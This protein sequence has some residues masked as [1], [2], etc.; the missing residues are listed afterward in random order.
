MNRIL[1]IRPLKPALPIDRLIVTPPLGIMYL[2]SV[3][4]N[5]NYEV[6]ILDM[7]LNKK[8]PDYYID[9]IR[10]F[11]PQAVGFSILTQE[12]KV[13]RHM[14]NAIKKENPDIKI[15]AGGPHATMYTEELLKN[16]EID[17]AVIGEGEITILELIREIEKGTIYPQIDGIAY[18]RDYKY[19]QTKPRIYIEDLDSIPFPAWDLVELIRYAQPFRFNAYTNI[20]HYAPI[21]TSRGCP[22]QCIYCH[23]IFG[24]TYRPRSPESVIE[25][26]KTLNI[27]FDINEIEIVDDCFN[28]DIKRAKKICELIIKSGMKIKISF[29]NGLRGDII[30]EELLT[31]LGKAGAYMIGY[32]IES[33]SMRLQKFTKRNLNLTRIK[34]NISN[35]A[36]QGILTHGLFMLGFPTETKDEML[37]TINFACSSRLHSACFFIAN[38]YS[39]TELYQIA[40]EMNKDVDI[41]PENFSYR[42]ANFNISE[43]NNKVLFSLQKKAYMRFYL[44]PGRI[45]QLIK[46]NRSNIQGFLI[47]LI[48]SLKRWFYLCISAR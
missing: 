4:R 41:E 3:L 48:M 39:N 33:A 1:F 15:I 20:K 6:K 10:L 17:Y 16:G 14:A 46:A 44:N 5:N 45:L 8:N 28:Y 18:L 29:P 38:P 35:T 43:V 7:R 19:I 23:S 12:A 2:A 40:R 47:N 31:I 21:I 32:G 11:K 13:A 24:K 34:R 36:K 27:R 42:A 26:I 30:D 37:E 9:E 22:Y 25:E